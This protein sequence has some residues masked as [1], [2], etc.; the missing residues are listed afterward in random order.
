[1]RLALVFFP[2]CVLQAA[3]RVNGYALGF[4]FTKK[5]TLLQEGKLACL[6]FQFERDLVKMVFSYGKEADNEE[7][8]NDRGD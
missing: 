7:P 1:L 2:H 5:I 3:F 4:N 8:E 6:M